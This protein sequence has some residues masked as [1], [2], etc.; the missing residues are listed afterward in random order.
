MDLGKATW[1]F[2]IPHSEKLTGNDKTCRYP[3]TALNMLVLLGSWPCR[4]WIASAVQRKFC[5]VL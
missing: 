2:L 1:K 4:M 3:G 5:S